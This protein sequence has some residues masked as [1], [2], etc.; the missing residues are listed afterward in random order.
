MDGQTVGAF[1][2]IGTHCAQ[3]RRNGGQP[4]TFLEPQPGSI[5]NHSSFAVTQGRTKGQGRHQIR[6]VPYVQIHKTG[7]V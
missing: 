5:G 7:S 2:D 6:A 1:V 3:Y 4:V